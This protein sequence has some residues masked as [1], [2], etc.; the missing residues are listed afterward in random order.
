MKGS[1]APPSPSEARRQIRFLEGQIR[2]LELECEGAIESRKEARAKLWQA[3]PTAKLNSPEFETPRRA[4]DQADEEIASIRR[5][6][7]NRE[8]KIRNLKPL[9]GDPEP[10]PILQ[11]AGGVW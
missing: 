5:K 6:I 2:E 10:L 11:A 4:M 8:A 1:K 3:L 7:Q 9:A